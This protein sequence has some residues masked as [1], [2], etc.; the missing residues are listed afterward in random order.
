M[1][2][3]HNTSPKTPSFQP[4][5]TRHAKKQE[6]VAY[7]QDKRQFMDPYRNWTQMLDSVGNDFNGQKR[8]MSSMSE[9]IGNLNRKLK[10]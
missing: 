8:N 7:I 2:S 5:S 1:Q 3:L 10:L 4:K 9:Q 6:R